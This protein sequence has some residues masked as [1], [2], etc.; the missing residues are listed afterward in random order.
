VDAI[1]DMT[2]SA[3]AVGSTGVAARL[4]QAAAED[5]ERSAEAVR[6][7]FP[8]LSLNPGLRQRCVVPDV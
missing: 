4:T 5:A 8:I 1:D 2:E 7:E 6:L 3:G